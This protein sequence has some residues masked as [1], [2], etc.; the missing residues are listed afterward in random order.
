VEGRC[1][2]PVCSKQHSGW[3]TQ[4]KR[5]A[6]VHCGSERIWSFTSEDRA[7]GG[8]P[9]LFPFAPFPRAVSTPRTAWRASASAPGPRRLNGM[10]GYDVC[11]LVTVQAARPAGGYLASYDDYDYSSIETACHTAKAPRQ[12]G[13]IR[14]KIRR[15]RVTAMTDARLPLCPPLLSYAGLR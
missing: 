10:A 2:P 14:I 7:P 6:R 4:S 5:R 1:L 8:R 13:R 3:R 12:V 9:L 15:K 11:A